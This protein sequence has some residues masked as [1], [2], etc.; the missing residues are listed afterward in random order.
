MSEKI[1]GTLISISPIQLRGYYIKEFIFQVNPEFDQNRP[2][3]SS[4][5]DLSF[6]CQFGEL[7]SDAV[8]AADPQEFE[9]NELWESRFSVE[10][11]KKGSSNRN[12][13]YIYS[14]SIT[15]LF[16]LNKKYNIEKRRELMAYNTQSILYGIVREIVSSFMDK[17]PFPSAILPTVSFSPMELT[18]DK[19]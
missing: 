11:G 10:Y 3:E 9:T 2:S 1:K 19:K 14:I 6:K 18:P 5:D 4:F 13:P 8:P 12:F 15:G 7:S 17:G 16:T